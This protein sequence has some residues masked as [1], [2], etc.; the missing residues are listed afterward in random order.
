MA[1][2]GITPHGL[3]EV[4]VTCALLLAVTLRV[5][6]WPT[7]VLDGCKTPSVDRSLPALSGVCDSTETGRQHPPGR[8]FFACTITARIRWLWRIRMHIMWRSL[9]QHPVK[10][11][12][13]L[14]NK[15]VRRDAQSC[16][17]V[18]LAL[19]LLRAA[20]CCAIHSIEFV[21]LATRVKPWPS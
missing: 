5:S 15:A 11:A 21:S 17:L 10:A 13:D 8:L 16:S 3:H 14:P 6:V 2:V 7:L 20:T 1:H 9:W 19:H 12:R 18:D 4:I